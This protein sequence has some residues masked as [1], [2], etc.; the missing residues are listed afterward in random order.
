M[1]IDRCRSP[2]RDFLASSKHPPRRMSTAIPPFLDPRTDVRRAG[3]ASKWIA[4]RRQ[5]A[6]NGAEIAARSHANGAAHQCHLHRERGSSERRALGNA[7]RRVPLA[8]E[9]A[10][11]E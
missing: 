2:V 11:P 6:Q 1:I 4:A 9:C 7:R 8:H 5:S 10:R 3:D